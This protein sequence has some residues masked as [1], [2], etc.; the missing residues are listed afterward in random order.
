MSEET[1]ILTQ[2]PVGDLATFA[3]SSFTHGP[4]T[5]RV[6]RKGSGPAVIVIT[7]MPGISPMVLGFADRVVA[8]GCTAVLP[9]LFGTAGND[10]THGNKVVGQARAFGTILRTCIRRDFTALAVGKS[11][12]VVDWLRAL[13]LQEH[14]TGGGPGVGAV[15]MCFTGGFALAMAVDPIVL[16]PVLS[17][18]SLP[19]PVSKKHRSSID[20]SEADLDVVAGRCTNDGLTVI[21]LRFEK[22]PYVPDERFRFL[23]D[24]LGDGF[25]AIELA[26]SDGNPLGPLPHRHSVLTGDLIDEPGEPTRDALDQVLALFR[27][28]L[29]PPI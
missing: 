7:E 8:L 10:P 20:T 27:S 13:A 25:V 28:K 19:F 23:E 18:P 2:A 15:G 16:A 11:S 26:Q 5:Y 14:R 12:R 21:G 1:R 29:L 17:Q 24:R 3:E 6:F 4:S 22:D 9:D